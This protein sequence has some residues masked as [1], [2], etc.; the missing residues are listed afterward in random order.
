[1]GLGVGSTGP[2]RPGIMGGPMPTVDP[3]PDATPPWGTPLHATLAARLLIGL[4]LVLA[5][6]AVVGLWA[7]LRPDPTAVTTRPT[8]LAVPTVRPAPPPPPPPAAPPADRPTATPVPD[9]LVG[10]ELSDVVDA[11]LA[12]GLRAEAQDSP[13]PAD[14]GI[15]SGQVLAV[16]PISGTPVAPGSTV[17]V[18]VA[19]EEDPGIQ[20]AD[21]AAPPGTPTE[22]SRLDLAAG[23]PAGSGCT[24]GP[25]PLP[26][27]QWVGYVT[28]GTETA[29]SFDLVCFDSATGRVDNTNPDLREVPL[30]PDAAIWCGS[31]TCNL[32]AIRPSTL[33]AIEVRGGT[34][35]ILHAGVAATG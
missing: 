30:A 35:F 13:V 22:P 9:D 4:A 10:G 25:G 18:T 28:T 6:A 27:G 11:L 21:P 15:A 8:P 26:D 14:T 3:D 31:I 2:P 19:R 7:I 12:V 29:V 32:P 33:S 17:I 24:P 20:P 5:V 1:M 23:D 16:S 34:A